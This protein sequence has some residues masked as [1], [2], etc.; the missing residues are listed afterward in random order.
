MARFIQTPL[1][2]IDDEQEQ[3]LLVGALIY[4]SDFKDKDGK[5]IMVR[6]ADGFQTDLASIPRLFRFLF[7]KNGKHRLASVPHDK[8]CRDKTFPRVLADKIF[9]EAMKVCKV[10]R[11]RRYLMYYAVRANTARLKLFGQAI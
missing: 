2:K 3:W 6:V 7:I 9:L 10:K 5:P 1:F 11:I 4:Q 8:L